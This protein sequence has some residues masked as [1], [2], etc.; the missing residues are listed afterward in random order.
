MGLNLIRC[1]IRLHD[2]VE[3]YRGGKLLARTANVVTNDLRQHFAEWLAGRTSA[4][5]PEYIGIGTK[6]IPAGVSE[7]E[8]SALQDELERERITSRSVTAE[9]EARLVS[10]F[11][12]KIGTG[13]WQE[14]GLFLE[15]ARRVLISSCDSDVNWTSQN[16]L[17]VEVTDYKE[18]AGALE[19]SGAATV[20]FQNA[21]LSPAYNTYSFTEADKLQLW[22]YID[23]IANLAGPLYIEISSSISNDVD[24]YEFSIPTTE[25]SAGWNWISRTINSATKIGSPD[26][27][28]IVRVRVHVEKAASAL[29]RIDRISLFG[30]QGLMWARAELATPIEKGLGEVWNVYWYLKIT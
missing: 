19:A 2:F 14:I 8:L 6:K 1:Q 26:L 25:L 5:Y 18:G 16:T 11:R 13:S 3:I 17:S 27:N 12:T 22:Y 21:A 23:D 29:S 7:R 30:V 10:T 20:D 28:S 4:P 15:K 9:R 24:E